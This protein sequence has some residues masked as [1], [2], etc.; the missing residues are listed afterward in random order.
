M[1][2]FTLERLEALSE[3]F[4][5]TIREAF[6]AGKLTQ[7]HQR[8]YFFTGNVP[9]HGDVPWFQ[10]HTETCVN[11]L[12]ADGFL[13]VVETWKKGAPKVVTLHPDLAAFLRSIQ[14]PRSAE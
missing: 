8:G 10:C 13:I 6:I 4:A 2:S 11:R 14:K 3:G 1:T 7:A 5:T 12:I 9:K